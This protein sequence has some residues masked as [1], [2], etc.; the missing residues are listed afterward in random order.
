MFD[1]DPVKYYK[2]KNECME[3]AHEKGS[4]LIQ[5]FGEYGYAVTD[6]R[7]SCEQDHNSL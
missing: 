1:E 7:I 2:D 4:G 6:S 3:V 5:T